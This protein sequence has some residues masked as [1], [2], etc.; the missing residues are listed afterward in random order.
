MRRIRFEHILLFIFAF[1]VLSGIAMVFDTTTVLSQEN[2]F[3]LFFKHIFY[4]IIGAI[5]ALIIYKLERPF[6]K[7]L[8]FGILLSSLTLFLLIAVYFFPPINRAHR[9]ITLFGFHF[10]PSEVSKLSLIIFFSVW[11]RRKKDYLDDIL[12]YIPILVLTL[13]YA[14]LI[15]FER[16]VGTSLFV[17]VLGFSLVFLFL[18]IKSLPVAVIVSILF[19][20]YAL[21]NFDY[22]KDRIDANLS[23]EGYAGTTAYQY[24]QSV[25]AVGS[26]GLGGVG[27][28]DSV[29]KLYFLPLSYNDYIYAI[30]GEELGFIG[31]ITILL[32]YIALIFIL[33]HLSRKVTDIASVLIII[34]IAFHIGLQ[35]FLNISVVLGLLPSKGLTLPF[36]SYGGSSQLVF[37]A[38]AGIAMS[39]ARE[40][41]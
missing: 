35:A 31:A 25:F 10:Q 12:S 26:G 41:K 33:L 17:I 1:L 23:P 28:G 39:I 37:L 21:L 27:L 14:V 34:G 22:I 19:F 11:L 9:W 6:Y 4:T 29:Q 3:N 2:K 7:E 8:W 40:A 13:L 18:G 20:V 15:F 30:I 5:L 16:D 32:L 38:E 36:I 24:F